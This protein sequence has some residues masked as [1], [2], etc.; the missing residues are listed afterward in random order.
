[1]PT[2]PFKT[3]RPEV[4]AIDPDRSKREGVRVTFVIGFDRYRIAA[5]RPPS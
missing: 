3:V 4:K 5:P 1:V 2:L